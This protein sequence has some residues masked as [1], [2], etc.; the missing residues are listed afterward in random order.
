MKTWDKIANSRLP[1]FARRDTPFSSSSFYPSLTNPS[2]PALP[3][4]LTTASLVARTLVE[5]ALRSDPRLPS[6]QGYQEM[7]V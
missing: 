6:E 3:Q 5:D 2:I 1:A 4:L 7:H